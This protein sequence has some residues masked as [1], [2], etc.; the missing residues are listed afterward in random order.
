MS[1]GGKF[2][3]KRD[4]KPLTGK[5]IFLLILNAVMLVGVLVSSLK[6]GSVTHALLTQ[7]AAKA[8]RG[9]NELRFAQVS[10]FLPEDGK[11]ALSAVES[12]RRTLEKALGC[13]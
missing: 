4:K 5:M 7:S 6:L 3:R 11:I 10:A 1:R 13:L 9:S 8:W 12:F 2:V